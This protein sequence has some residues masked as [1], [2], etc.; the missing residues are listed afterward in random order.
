M[1]TM[2]AGAFA[3]WLALAGDALAQSAPLKWLSAAG[4]NATLVRS[5]STVLNTLVSINTT[6]ALYYLKLYNKSTAPTCGTD[7]PLWTVPIPFGATSS[8]GGVVLP[9]G[10]LIFP[11][12]LGFCLTGGIADNDTARRDRRRHQHGRVRTVNYFQRLLA[13]REITV[14]RDSQFLVTEKLGNKQSLT[15]EGFL[16]IE[17]TPIARTGVQIYAPQEVHGK[18]HELYKDLAAPPDGVYRVQRDESEVFAPETIASANGKPLVDEHPEQIVTPDTHEGAP[19]TVMNPRRGK[20]AHDDLLVADI[21]VYN[22]RLIQL[23]RDGKRELS[24]GYD[25]DYEEIEPGRLAQKNIRINHVALVESG[26]CGPRCAIGDRSHYTHYSHKEE[27]PVALR[28]KKSVFDGIRRMLNMSTS[29]SAKDKEELEKALEEGEADARDEPSE[30]E[31]MAERIRREQER[32]DKPGGKDD[33][34]PGGPHHIEIHNHM[35]AGGEIKGGDPEHDDDPDTG[36]GGIEERVARLETAVHELAELCRANIEGATSDEDNP[37]EERMKSVED[38][39]TMLTGEKPVGEGGKEILGELELE[40][41]TGA[42]AVDVR[43]AKDSRYLRDSFQA[44]AAT[45]DILAPGIRLPTFDEKAAPVKSFRSIDALRRIA[46]DFAYQQPQTRGM[47]DE[48]LGGRAFDSKDMSH[49]IARSIFAAVGAMKRSLN[50][51][52]LRVGDAS[53]VETRE[54]GRPVGGV[55]TL[56]DYATMLNEHYKKTA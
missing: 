23:I 14:D 31:E 9:T 54:H 50:N 7:T 39:I 52:S 17:D 10:G 38:A 47:I 53:S 16:L 6:V 19:G 55:K 41:P 22:K 49:A 36:A 2:L 20:G 42:A 27:V 33:D 24:C 26:R 40:A 3:V 30:R 28:K 29:L 12:G 21:I 48:V 18:D 35:P 32:K 37:F 8:G 45:A 56:T 13:Q 44:T 25:V 11:L 46:L 1:R 34:E 5:G 43:R 15:P 4:T 51:K